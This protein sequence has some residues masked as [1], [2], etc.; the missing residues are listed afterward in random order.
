MRAVMEKKAAAEAKLTRAKVRIITQD[1]ARAGRVNKLAELA[2]AAPSGSTY[3][4]AVTVAQHKKCPG[5]AAY[6]IVREWAGTVET[7][8]VC[9]DWEANG[10]HQRYNWNPRPQAPVVDQEAK[11]AERRNVIANN[12]AWDTATG[13]RQRFL[14]TFLARKSPDKGSAAFVAGE[15]LLG[16]FEIRRAMERGSTMLYELLGY[17]DRDARKAAAAAA[18]TTTDARAQVLSLAVVLAAIEESLSRDTW[19]NPSAAAGRYFTFLTA[20]GYQLSDVEQL[21]LPKKK[22]TRKTSDKATPS[23][24][25]QA[26]DDQAAEEQDTTGAQQAAAPAA[27]DGAVAA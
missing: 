3:P 17:K 8:Y 7:V 15:L 27:T 1:A 24:P 16:G 25:N 18:A 13:V 5:H 26:G 4:P 21:V 9:T 20:H 11:R 10:H 22:T 19:R 14:K 6:I 12:K 23:D 2:A